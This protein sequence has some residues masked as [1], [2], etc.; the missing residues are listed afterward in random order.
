MSLAHERLEKLRRLR[1]LE[2]AKR[3]EL[4]ERFERQRR[5]HKA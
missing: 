5:L 1:E 3:D 2:V 4:I